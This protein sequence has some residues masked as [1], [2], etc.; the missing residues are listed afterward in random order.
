MFVLMISVFLL[1]TILWVISLYF[2]GLKEF[3]LF[4]VF[5]G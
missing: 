5:L 1:K 3:I 4:E 2:W